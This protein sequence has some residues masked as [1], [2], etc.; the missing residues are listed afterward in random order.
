MQFDLQ[1]KIKNE[2]N[3]YQYLKENSYWVK[4]LNRNAFAYP[5]FV[6][7]MKDL[8]RLR[9]SDKISDAIDQIDLISSFLNAFRS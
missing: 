5:K 1:M 8:Y 4:E 2:K 6:D 3:M 9:T 7:A